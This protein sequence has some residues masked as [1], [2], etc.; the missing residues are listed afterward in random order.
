MDGDTSV[1]D[2]KLPCR[3]HPHWL[4]PTIYQSETSPERSSTPSEVIGL[5]SRS[6]VSVAVRIS[7]QN[8]ERNFKVGHSD[9]LQGGFSSPPCI[10]YVLWN[11]FITNTFAPQVISRTF[12]FLILLMWLPRFYIVT[13]WY[14]AWIFPTRQ[15][16]ME[17]QWL[18][19]SLY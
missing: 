1:S 2:I 17:M 13:V 15:N 8:A 3:T 11:V 4:E 14:A 9:H 6:M 19:L 10:F 12:G 7:S 5:E 18:R 16:I